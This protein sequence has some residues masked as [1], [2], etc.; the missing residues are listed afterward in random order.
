MEE[1]V[2]EE[3]PVQSTVGKSYLFGKGDCSGVNF[4]GRESTEEFPEQSMVEGELSV[5]DE[6]EGEA[7]AEG[8]NASRHTFPWMREYG[9]D[10][11]VFDG[12]E[13]RSY[14]FSLR[15]DE[16]VV[17]AMGV[18]GR[19]GNGKGKWMVRVE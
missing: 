12:R 4:R 8:S 11:I 16:D 9:G 19:D 17:Y 10:F 1:K 2:A 15:L 14:L 18:V 7:E 6:W 3:I 13:E 5:L